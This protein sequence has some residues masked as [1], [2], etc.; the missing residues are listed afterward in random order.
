MSRSFRFLLA[1]LAVVL[2][3][4]LPSGTASGVLLVGLTSQN[5]LQ[6]VEAGGGFTF[7]IGAGALPDGESLRALDFRPAT[8][9]LFL[10]AASGR[11]YARASLAS[12]AALTLVGSIAPPAGPFSVD[13]NPV[14]DRI[15][16]VTE[17]GQNLRLN[18]LTGT[19]ANTDTPL[20]YAAGDTATGAPRL[21]AV[22]YTSPFAGVSVT[23]LY[24]IDADRGTLVRQGG[25]NGDPSPNG[26]VLTTIGSLGLGTVAVAGLDVTPAGTAYAALRPA[27]AP[28][29]IYTIDLQTGRATFVNTFAEVGSET[30]VDLAV[31]LPAGGTN[32]SFL[33][34]SARAPGAGG[35][36]FTTDLFLT[37]AGGFASQ[38]EL[39]FLDHDVDG[40]TG[41]VR[42]V[43]LSPGASTTLTDV[44]GGLFGLSSGYGAIR[45]VSDTDAVVASSETSTPGTYGHAVPP[46]PSADF[47]TGSTP[48]LV[49]GVRENGA[50]RTNLVLANTT[51]AAATARVEL[52]A[53]DGRS[54]GL[55]TYALPPLG[56]TQVNRVVRDLGV[57]SDLDD[58]RLSIAAASGSVASYAVRIDNRTNDPRTLLPRGVPPSFLLTYP[59]A[60]RPE[61]GAP[62]ATDEP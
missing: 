28:T 39:K 26:G 47:I 31:V 37:N 45:I 12:T 55:K 52:F 54:L 2:A 40:R 61:D 5:R 41:P 21:A 20:A 6:I 49:V 19:V 4:A 56:M 35:S 36:F 60:E 24:G 29:R 51:G 27:G 50:F 7:T 30:I 25:V 33:P 15:R 13:F 34:S 59:G 43:S 58:G 32:V 23:T 22:G 16:L 57:A 17:S 44:L 48:R 9:E 8:G 62:P 11:V 3:A 42:V 46:V 10:V 53:A 1:A 38:V 18:P 14:P